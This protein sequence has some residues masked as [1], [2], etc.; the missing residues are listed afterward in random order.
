MVVYIHYYL[1][2]SYCTT[3]LLVTFLYVLTHSQYTCFRTCYVGGEQGTCLARQ[4][5]CR[6]ITAYV[7][8]AM[9]SSMKISSPN[10]GSLPN[11]GN[12][13]NSA[14]CRYVGFAVIHQEVMTVFTCRFHIKCEG[15]KLLFYSFSTQQLQGQTTCSTISGSH[16][17]DRIKLTFPG[18]GECERCG[19]IADPQ[20]NNCID[21]SGLGNEMIAEFVSNRQNEEPGTE[22]LVNCALPGIDQNSPTTDPLQGFN[23]DSITSQEECTSPDGGGPRNLPQVPP[24]VSAF[25]NCCST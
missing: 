6:G 12:Y 2:A 17:V 23:F 21:R 13:R 22:I 10:Y 9:I 3:S 8:S 15:E 7:D 11:I 19:N 4:Q 25:N 16:C 1:C 20:D 18:L 24:P 14:V 5:F